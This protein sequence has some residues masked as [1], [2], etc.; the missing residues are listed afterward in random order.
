M[1]PF[2]AQP[3]WQL[4][5]PFVNLAPGLKPGQLRAN[6]PPMQ[7]KVAT[8]MHQLGIAIQ[9]QHCLRGVQG[10][11]LHA[12]FEQLHLLAAGALGQHR[13]HLAGA[14][15]GQRQVAAL[16]GRGRPGDVDHA[17]N[18]LAARHEYRRCG[19]SPALD[20]LTEMLGTVHLHRLAHGQGG[21]DAVGADHAFMP[22]PTLHQ[23]HVLRGVQCALVASHL[24]NH[25]IRVG[26]DHDR[27]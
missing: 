16:V 19:T 22:V 25:A 27:A 8:D 3:G 17:Q 21:A 20:A 7:G 6:A 14:G 13:F 10:A 5:R 24:Q 12:G 1:Q 11:K 2:G 4:A 26:Q 23:V 18:L 9:H 15:Q